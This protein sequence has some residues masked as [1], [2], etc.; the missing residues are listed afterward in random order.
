MT[1]VPWNGPQIGVPPL[2]LLYLL[3][4]EQ[5]YADRALELMDMTADTAVGDV[6]AHGYFGY[7]GLGYDWLH[8]N[9]GMT[10][11]RRQAYVAKMIHWSDTVWMNENYEGKD[12]NGQDTDAVIETGSAHLMLGCA[13]YGDAPE[14][15]TLLDRGWWMWE[16]GQGREPAP[17]VEQWTMAR[18]IRTWIADALGGHFYPGFL[19]FMG[20]DG[21]GLSQYW[22][23]LRTACHYDINTQEP[24]LKSFWA[25]VIRTTLDLTDPTRTLL[26]HTGDWQDPNVISERTYLYAMLAQASYH[27]ARAGDTDWAAYARGYARAIE[28]YHYSEFLEFFFS[29]PAGPVQDPYTS[30]LPPIRFCDGVDYLFFR[31][32]WDAAA[33]WGLFS[34][35]GGEP[36]DH[37]TPDTGNFVLYRN[38]QYLTKDCRMY[39]GNAGGGFGVAFNNLSI[40]NGDTWLGSPV[41]S[42]FQSRAEITRH[43]EHNENPLF[44]YAMVQADGQ[45][46]EDP[47]QEGS[48]QRVKTYRRHFFWSGDY[49]VVFDRLRTVDCGWCRYR[50]RAL[51]PPALEGVTITQSSPDG[52]QRLLHR[53]LEPENSTFRLID[54]T[55][56]WANGFQDWEI[57][58]AERKWQYEIQPPDSDRV[59][60]LNVMQMGGAG[61]S[62]FDTLEHLQATGGGGVRIC[63]WV[64]VFA[65]EETLLN[66]VQYTILQPAAP[67]Y[68]LVCDL[69]SGTYQVLGNGQLLG[70]VKVDDQD[71]ATYVV[72]NNNDPEFML[73]LQKTSSIDDWGL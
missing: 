38:G 41:M 50:L 8:D 42:G 2:A 28:S 20:S 24:S 21:D 67:Q 12:G 57:D 60:L 63:N 34:G 73:T 30:G 70:T 37:Q 13:L 68:H 61:L 56:A 22:I 62:Q 16:H 27:A 4:G 46:N 5:R 11:A 71:H 55:Q 35:Q 18:P 39:P 47:T 59:N 7:L 48:L 49:T 40:Q 14:A 69:E 54:E 66:Q 51:T 33:T 29:D 65:D 58:L 19:Y 23:T 31:S 64:A 15:Q 17:G 1:E 72:T 26:H 32:G 3:T 36:A 53:T 43:R 44:A 45:W 52:K 9:P 6:A 25:N 10:A